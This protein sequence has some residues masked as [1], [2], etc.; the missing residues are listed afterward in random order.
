M[1][2]CDLASRSVESV[3]GMSTKMYQHTADARFGKSNG[4]SKPSNRVFSDNKDIHKMLYYGANTPIMKP[5][6]I[7]QYGNK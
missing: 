5:N 3:I 1:M 4:S 7:N 2:E 6:K